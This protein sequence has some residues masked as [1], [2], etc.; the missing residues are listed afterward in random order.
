MSWYDGN[1]MAKLAA[2][3]YAIMFNE[4]GWEEAEIFDLGA[5]A[6]MVTPEACVFEPLHL[7]VITTGGNYLGQTVV[8]PE[9]EPNINVCI[10]PNP[11]LIMKV[12]NDSFSGTNTALEIPS[13]DPIIGTWTGTV[14]NNGFEMEISITI[15]ESCQLEE[16]CGQFDITTVSC[17]GSLTWVGMDGGMYQFQ[18]SEKTEGCG[19]GIDYLLPQSDGTVMYISRGDYGETSGTLQRPP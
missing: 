6:I 5:A 14:L 1:E 15:K 11:D 19:E 16:I 12:L 8:I 13:I 2:E 7:D 10:N 4:Y 9:R 3:L 17:S 18:A